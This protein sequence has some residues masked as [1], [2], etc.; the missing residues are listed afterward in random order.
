MVR[1]ARGEE[2][3]WVERAELFT[4]VEERGNDMKSDYGS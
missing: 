3:E 2:F 1:A 4:A